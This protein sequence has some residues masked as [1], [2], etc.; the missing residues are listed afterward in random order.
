MVAPEKARRSLWTWCRCS[1]RWCRIAAL[2]LVLF[3][4]LALTW[5]RF[6]GLPEFL[7][8]RIVDE[9]SRHG[10]TAGFSDLRFHWFRGLVARDLKVAWGGTNGP[11][12]AI[13][14]ADLDIAPPPWHASRE[15]VRGLRIRQGT[16]VFP[17]P[18]DG[19]PGRELRVE[20]VAA[21]IRFLPDDAW[22]VRRLGAQ[23]LGLDLEVRAKITHVS[24]LRGTPPKSPPNPA[25]A[26]QRRR[27]LRGVLEELE[28]WSFTSA[29]RLEASLQLDGRAPESAS[30]NA[31]LTIPEVHTPHGDM[32]GLRLSLRSPAQPANPSLPDSTN[33]TSSLIT[34]DLADI[35]TGD[36]GV[37]HV[38][39]RCELQGPPRPA[40]PSQATWQVSAQHLFLRGFRARQITLRGTNDLLATITGVSR[41]DLENLPV[42]SQLSAGADSIEIANHQRDAIAGSTL[43]VTLDLRHT[44]VPRL[45]QP[46]TN[47]SG[48][49]LSNPPLSGSLSLDLASL[50]G[51]PGTS[52]PVHV[53]GSFATRPQHSGAPEHLGFWSRL[54]P[55]TASLDTTIA[56]VRSPKLEA[57]QI[58]VGVDWKPPT[59]IIRKLSASL[60]EGGLEA[61]GDLDVVTRQARLHAN[62]SFDIHGF[63]P[64]FPPRSR[65][66][67]VRYQWTRPPL[68]EG[69][70]SVVLPAWDDPKPDWKGGVKS[71]IR[72]QGRF[73]VGQGGF[74]GVPFDSAESSISYDGEFVRLPDLRTTRPEGGQQITVVY[75]DRTREYQVDGKGIVDP[76][77]LKPLLGEKS[78]AVTDLFAFKAPVQATVS[79]WGPWNEGTRQSIVGVARAPGLE[80]RGHRFD[81]LEASV[82]YTNQSLT[83]GPVRITRDGGVLT[84]DQVRYE[85]DSDLLT[86]GHITNT[87][88]VATVA[89][90]I[91]PEF[92]EKLSYY[93]FD[94]TPTVKATG[95]IRPRKE[96]TANLDFDIEG[97]PFHFWRFSADRIATRLLWHRNELTLTNITASFY[98]GALNGEAV[99]D[100]SDPREGR[101]RFNAD[102]RDSRLEDLLKEATEARTNVAQGSFDLTLNIDSAR[103]SDIRTWNGTGN[104]VLR[105][106]L[107]WDT[108]LFGFMSPVLNALIP[109]I[110]NNRAKRAD[111][112]FVVSNGVFH[113][114]DL[115]IACPPAKLLY[116]GT[117]DFDQHI[118]AKVEAQVLGE[119]LGFGP[120]VGLVLK[121]L[122]KLFE[123][124]VTGTLTKFDAEPLYALPKVILFPL[125]PLRVI[126]GI[127][128][129]PPL[130]PPRSE[131]ST[132]APPEQP[133]PRP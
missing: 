105:D 7:R 18:V 24:A 86:L 62:T 60:Y 39:G 2:A 132:N 111:A 103:T 109:G 17:L 88:D 5:L 121:P 94:T 29:P 104:A 123:Y 27:L 16:L 108:P 64:W 75:S 58:S 115:N 22:E 84:A 73:K 55:F 33:T 128:T 19:E 41:S 13:S 46:S 11:S 25:A 37:D 112:T 131:P 77:I 35:Q 38:S 8:T 89:A 9:L 72:A 120:L 30:G 69:D 78:A 83:A 90:A 76:P 12:I 51:Q 82:V 48:A 80:F 87:I 106:G 65:E 32:R 50:S 56:A 6:A 98:R 53:Q 1:F 44:L 99:F 47:S 14:E 71:S 127:F 21:D 70:A 117:V 79:V 97:G 68:V 100:L 124:R 130:A 34:L 81:L 119:M 67:F 74:K 114:K 116:R 23:F 107:L 122:T 43:L 31:Y 85:F 59:A 54:W 133:A 36:G 52:G 63:D 4:L 95:T 101:Y 126:K 57:G 102:I 113:T 96:G 61:R 125:Q 15:L 10:V 26:V 91:N 20:K 28:R 49:S 45:P 118:N 3:I 40:L 129:S 92:P 110:G 66:N 93:R 42:R